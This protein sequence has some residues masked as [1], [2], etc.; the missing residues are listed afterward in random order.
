MTRLLCCFTRCESLLYLP[1][2]SCSPTFFYRI[3][4]QQTKRTAKNAA[5][6]CLVRLPD[7]YEGL[8]RTQGRRSPFFNGK[9]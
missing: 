6:S 2:F 8:H 9:K 3:M 4:H 5:Q 7:Q 1:F